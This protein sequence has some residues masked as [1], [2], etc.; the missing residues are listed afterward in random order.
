M[1][2]V[3]ALVARSWWSWWEALV[4]VLLLSSTTSLDLL[5]ITCDTARTARWPPVVGGSV[6]YRVTHLVGYVLSLNQQA[7]PE[8]APSSSS[9]SGPR[10]FGKRHWAGT[11]CDVTSISFIFVVQRSLQTAGGSCW[12]I[13]FAAIYRSIRYRVRVAGTG[14][15]PFTG[16]ALLAVPVRDSRDSRR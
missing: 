15:K 2:H 8:T 3:A 10:P 14:P 12:I 4:V 1:G 16:G 9:S 7:D 5:Q 6:T 13:L 11:R